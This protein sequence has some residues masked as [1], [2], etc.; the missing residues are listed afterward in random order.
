[1]MITKSLH[2][3]VAEMGVHW[4]KENFRVDNRSDWEE[5]NEKIMW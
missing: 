5:I 2:V 4:Q 3:Q 1:M